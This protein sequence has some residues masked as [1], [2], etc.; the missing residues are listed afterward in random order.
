MLKGASSKSLFASLVGK[1]A[2]QINIETQPPVDFRA[3]DPDGQFQEYERV[4]TENLDLRKQLKLKEETVSGLRIR[5]FTLNSQL[6]VQKRLLEAELKKNEA[7]GS[8]LT[9]AIVKNVELDHM[10]QNWLASEFVNP[11][12]T[13]AESESDEDDSDS[14]AEENQEQGAHN[15]VDENITSLPTIKEDEAKKQ[16]NESVESSTIDAKV[17]PAQP[18]LTNETKSTNVP[19][20]GDDSS[21]ACN[22]DQKKEENAP[23]KALGPGFF[24]DKKMSQI[25]LS[26]RGMKALKSSCSL[27]KSRRRLFSMKFSVEI[28]PQVPASVL[29]EL[30]R[31]NFDIFSRSLD[32]LK[33]CVI[34]I[35][36]D[37]GLLQEFMIKPSTLSNFI[38]QMS[39]EYRDN[40]YHNFRHAVDV[41]QTVYYYLNKT[42]AREILQPIDV[43]AVVASAIS[44]DVG[45]PGQNNAFQINTQSELSR[46]YNDSSVLESYHAAKTFEILRKHEYPVKDIERNPAL[47]VEYMAKKKGGEFDSIPENTNIFQSLTSAQFKDVRK[48]MVNMILSTD[49]AKHFDMTAK[50]AGLSKKAETGEVLLSADKKEDREFLCGVLL[51]CADISN[52]TKPFDV[53]KVWSDRVRDEFFQQGDL[54]KAYGLPV[55]PYMDREDSNQARTTLNFIDFVATPLF[56][57]LAIMVEGL[58]ATCQN[59]V[60]NRTRWQEILEQNLKPDIKPTPVVIAPQEVSQKPQDPNSTTTNI[61]SEPTGDTLK[62]KEKETY[63]RRSVI[64]MQQIKQV[65]EAQKRRMSRE[66]SF[67][68][69]AQSTNATQGML[70]TVLDE[71]HLDNE[72]G[73]SPDNSHSHQQNTDSE[74]ISP[75]NQRSPSKLSDDAEGG[76]YGRYTSHPSQ[77]PSSALAQDESPGLSIGSISS[78]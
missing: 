60:E 8:E 38:T 66:Q 4:R 53:G 37:L 17:D 26:S 15:A 18:D 59:L 25:S 54:E 48:N 7:R 43:L 27:I 63:R 77:K 45:H 11:G 10:T 16:V 57:A 74:D 35:F 69:P 22:L 9:N 6:S 40:P 70:E 52:V 23:K 21:N 49:M 28:R 32:E 31:E 73:S 71:E 61:S 14:D 65:D 3:L 19:A 47:F 29:E 30:Q 13:A 46:I 78:K 20:L 72:A 36:E 12:H 68:A 76:T 34:Y 24:A 33:Q 56:T 51:H 50:L 44:H 58:N 1:S 64:M 39:L 5:L 62:E 67:N 2:S 55:S 41:T 75:I 42:N